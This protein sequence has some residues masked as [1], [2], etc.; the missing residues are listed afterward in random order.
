MVEIRGTLD[1][2]RD[3]FAHAFV[4][5][6]KKQVKNAGKKAAKKATRKL[7]GWQRYMKVKANQIR[8]KSGTKKGLLNLKAMG[9]KYRKGKKK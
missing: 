1:E 8:Y 4:E 2:L 6:T 3:L 9:V 7:S 5:E